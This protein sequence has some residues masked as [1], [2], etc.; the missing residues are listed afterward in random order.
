MKNR[1][2]ISHKQRLDDLF[3]Q[4][5][6]LPM[7][8]RLQGHWARYLCV[9]VSGFLEASVVAIYREYAQNRAEP[10]ITRFVET[11]LRGFRN[12]NMERIIQLIGSFNPGWAKDIKEVTHGQLTES[13]NSIVNIRNQIAHGEDVGIG[14]PTIRSYYENAV[15][16]IEL[17]EQQCNT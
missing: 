15:K 2:V 4:V 6:N 10:N 7:E 17:L 12:P 3:E 1:E 16:V 9:L 11:E 8:Q 5:K 13:I 14:Y